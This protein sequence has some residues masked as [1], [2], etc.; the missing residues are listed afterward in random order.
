[1]TSIPTMFLTSAESMLFTLLAT[2][3]VV[4]WAHNQTRGHDD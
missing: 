4:I 2:V 3:F 1:M